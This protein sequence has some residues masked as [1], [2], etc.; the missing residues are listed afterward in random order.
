MAT[1]GKSSTDFIFGIFYIPGNV[2]PSFGRLGHRKSSLALTPEEEPFD[3]VPV[4]NK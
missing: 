4:S 2:C 1:S 3:V